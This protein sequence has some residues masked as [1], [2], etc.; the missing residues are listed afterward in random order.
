MVSH[1]CDSCLSHFPAQKNGWRKAIRRGS[2]DYVCF[3]FWLAPLV[4]L[5]V[6]LAA[7]VAVAGQG[8]GVNPTTYN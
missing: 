1:G 6:L 5:W 3:W 2:D 8:L 7:G 4:A